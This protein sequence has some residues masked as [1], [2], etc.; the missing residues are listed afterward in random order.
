[1]KKSI[2][3]LLLS[4]LVLFST[5]VSAFADDKYL[6]SS[7]SDV[8]NNY[9]EKHDLSEEGVR[10]INEIRSDGHYFWKITSKSVNGYSYGGWRM[11]PSGK[12]P[13]TLGLT[14]TK[15]YNLAVT[16]TISGSYTSIGTISNS[17]GVSIGVSKSYSASYSVKVPKG[18]RYRI[19]Y[20]PHFKVYKVV[21]T[22]FY[23]IDGYSV[24]TPITK[25]SYVKV[26][27]NW[28]YSWKR[29]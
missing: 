6:V 12:G 24:K 26:F 1:M 15:G 3:I 9:I 11:G 27:S 22:Q 25:T 16:N 10:N 14:S 7:Y 29:I 28:D 21:E 19:I 13:A 23:R 17:L 2:S 5:H 18:K 20:R 8:A 4:L